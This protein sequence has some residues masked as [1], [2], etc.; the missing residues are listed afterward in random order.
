MRLSLTPEN[1]RRTH[2]RERV[3]VT[4][5]L[6]LSLTPPNQPRIYRASS[7]PVVFITSKTVRVYRFLLFLR[8]FAKIHVVNDRSSPDGEI[9]SGRAEIS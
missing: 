9:A 3:S 6:D 5:R 8:K 7:A 2:P 1:H 4:V